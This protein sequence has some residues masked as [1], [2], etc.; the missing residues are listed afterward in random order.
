MIRVI[1]L[2]ALLAGQAHA[3]APEEL[4]KKVSVS[5]PEISAPG[6]RQYLNPFSKVGAGWERSDLSK[7]ENEFSLSLSLKGI[8]EARE[9]KRLAG[10]LT[11]DIE[12]SQKLVRSTSLQTAYTA[13]ISAALAKEQNASVEELRDLL[14]KSQKLNAIAAR[15][16][17][18][19]VKNVLKGSSELQKSIEE[20]IEI[21]SQLAGIRRF[22]S[23]HGLKLEELDTNELVSPEEIA[24]SIENLPVNEVALTSKKILTEVEVTKHDANHSIAERSKLLDGLKLSMEQAPKKEN[25]YKVEVSFNLPFLAAQD[26]GDFKDRLKAAEAEVKGQQAML[27]ESL[28]SAGLAEVLKRKISLYRAMGEGPK[29]ENNDLLRQD[30]ALALDLKRTSVALR[31]TRA[32]LLAEIRSLYVSL[33]LE[34]ETLARQPD[35]NHLSRVKRKI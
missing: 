19:D 5:T 22:L 17:R 2:S 1:L 11:Q 18:A 31:L 12:V 7:R 20:V 29:W 3:Y 30:P 6:S 32:N 23:G 21:E 4:L 14:G 26:L 15:R 10:A 35:T 24:A 9:Y 34:T 28:K 8:S 13:L 16:D 33:L 25:V 27:E